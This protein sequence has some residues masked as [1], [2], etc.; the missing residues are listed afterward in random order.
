MAELPSDELQFILNSFSFLLWGALVMWMAAGFTML[1]AGSVRTK[2]ASV[3]CLKNVGL[4]AVAAIAYYVIG[5]NLMYVDVGTVMGSVTFLRGPSSDELALL[6]GADGA[7]E[8]VIGTEY[9]VMSDWFFRGCPADSRKSAATVH[10]RY[11][12]FSIS[13]RTPSSSSR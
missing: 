4:Y 1:E 10:S 13:A 3:I 12:A 8:A 5:Y 6:A 11:P 7:R 2:N 9:A